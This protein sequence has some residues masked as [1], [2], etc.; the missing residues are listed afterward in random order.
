VVDKRLLDMEYWR[1]VDD[2]YKLALDISYGT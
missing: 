2:G 1:D